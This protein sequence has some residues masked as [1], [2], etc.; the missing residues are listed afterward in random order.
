[1]RLGPC[2]ICDKPEDTVG[3]AGCNHSVCYECC[4]WIGKPGDDACGDWF[5]LEC[6]K[7]EGDE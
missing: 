7:E 6:L 5:C 2:Q 1:M 3:C 4:R